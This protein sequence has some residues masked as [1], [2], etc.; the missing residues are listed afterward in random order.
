LKDKLISRLESE[1]EVARTIAKLKEE[2]PGW[3][4]HDLGDGP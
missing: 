3:S 4:I 1:E 2:Y